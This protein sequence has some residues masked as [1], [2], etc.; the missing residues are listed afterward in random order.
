MMITSYCPYRTSQFNIERYN[1][2]FLP[3]GGQSRPTRKDLFERS[4]PLAL[5]CE[6]WICFL[7]IFNYRGKKDSA[8]FASISVF[9]GKTGRWWHIVLQNKNHFVT[10]RVIRIYTD[11]SLQ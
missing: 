5:I 7:I 8:I 6:I 4:V 1:M 3:G 10:Y 11:H 9:V 2:V